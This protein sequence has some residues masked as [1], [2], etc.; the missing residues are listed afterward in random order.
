MYLAVHREEGVEHKDK[1]KHQLEPRY[2]GKIPRNQMTASLALLTHLV[3]MVEVV[4]R[5]FSD[6]LTVMSLR[7][8]KAVS[9]VTAVGVTI[10]HMNRMQRTE[11]W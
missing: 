6:K 3:I 4:D 10:G 2:V 8:L 9:P 1:D 11:L 7:M 5:V